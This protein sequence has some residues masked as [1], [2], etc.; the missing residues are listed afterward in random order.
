MEN[1]NYFDEME[2]KDSEIINAFNTQVHFFDKI[3]YNEK[4]SRIDAI[5]IDKKGR[6]VHAEIKQRTGKYGNFFEFIKSFNSIF[7]E[8]GKLD[9][10]SHTMNSGHT[11]QEKEILISIFNNGDV[12]LIHD[13]DKP[14]EMEW[15]PNSRI[16]NPGT[17]RWEFEHRVGLYWYNAIIFV[18]E[19]N[20]YIRKTKEEIQNIL[21]S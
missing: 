14:Q 16:F 19:D 11:L 10:F 4:G 5:A 18:K 17:K 2:K 7:L 20:K 9:A 15:F 13:L 3:Y 21:F 8:T 12:I 6:K 1:K